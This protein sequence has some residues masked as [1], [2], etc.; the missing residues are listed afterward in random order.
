MN[1]VWAVKGWAAAHVGATEQTARRY[2]A[3]LEARGLVRVVAKRPLAFALTTDALARFAPTY[4]VA[5]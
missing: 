4:E 5:L 1:R 2:L 3:A